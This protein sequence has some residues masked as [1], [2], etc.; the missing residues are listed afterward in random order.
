MG[1]KHGSALISLAEA[2]NGPI[3]T[4]ATNDSNPSIGK[5]AV[6]LHYHKHHGYRKLMQEQRHELSEW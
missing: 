4:I 2:E 3:T 5:T 6:H 1:I